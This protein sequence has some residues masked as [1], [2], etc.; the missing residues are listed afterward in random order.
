MRSITRRIGYE[1]RS[2]AYR[3]VIIGDVHLGNLHSDE[4]L[5]RRLAAE[6]AAEP[7][8]YWVG[9]GDY[10]ECINVKD[11]RFDPDELVGWLM[12]GTQL[13]N[14]ARAEMQRF[15]EIMRP[16]ADKCIALI[17]GNHERDVL[18]KSETDVYTML[19]DAL[20]DG[21]EAH[22]LDHR[23]LIRLSFQRGRSTTWGLMIYATHGSV[24]GRKP[25]AAANRLD[26]LTGHVGRVDVVLQGHSHR[27]QRYTTAKYE[28][29]PG[30]IVSV[31]VHCATILPMCSDMAY[32]DRRDLGPV[33][34]GYDDLIV[35]PNKQMVEIR[36]HI[37]G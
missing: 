7:N 14:L 22:R 32:A 10:C 24:G 8:T 21:K 9:L 18:D 36:E 30:G 23:G 26:E 37:G 13:R 35:T 2:D 12:G 11:K 20:A 6:I 33:V 3:I 17:E 29:R 4:R 34:T 5:L 16:C 25:G 31:P 28:L 19:I 15:I 1:S 27:A